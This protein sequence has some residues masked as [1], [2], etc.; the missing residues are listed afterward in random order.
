MGTNESM[1][2][3]VIFGVQVSCL[4]MRQLIDLVLTE[5]QFAQ[6]RLV[7]TLNVDHVVNLRTNHTFRQAYNESWI[8]TI[9]GFPV[10]LIAK[11]KGFKVSKISGSDL[12]PL[13]LKQMDAEVSRPFFL[14][15][16]EE[17]GE[18]IVLKLR[19][20]GFRHV[21]FLVPP[22]DFENDEKISKTICDRIL[23]AK[24][25]HLFIG[26]GAPKSELWAYRHKDLI[27]SCYVF[28]VGAA[29]DYFAGRSRRAPLFMQAMGIE[30]LWRLAHNPRRLWRRYL[31][32]LFLFFVLAANELAIK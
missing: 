8:N 14:A 13:L 25:T 20:R 5:N 19:E 21:G 10:Y 23:E 11:M 32:G 22:L 9:D 3:C 15:A 31:K 27:G 12:V 7:H 24:A 1:P 18:I 30:W 6:A 2:N 28:C 29:L 17:A 16:T 26:V 4:S